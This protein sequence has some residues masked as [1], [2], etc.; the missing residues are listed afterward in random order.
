MITKRRPGGQGSKF[1][2]VFAATLLC[3]G[4]DAEV[5]V[6]PFNEPIRLVHALGERVHF[7][8]E[9]E[10]GMVGEARFDGVGRD[11]R[12]VAAG[13]VPRQLD[14]VPRIRDHPQVLRRGRRS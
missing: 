10:G 6:L 5:V 1:R 14:R 12:R 9:A 3:T 11:L 4:P 2:K 7:S 13:F 8:R